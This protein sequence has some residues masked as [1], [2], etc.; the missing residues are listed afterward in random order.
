MKAWM[1]AGLIGAAV[2]VVLS[3]LGLIPF[4]ACITGPLTFLAYIGIGSLAA[5][6]LPARRVAGTAAGQGA[7]AALLAGFIGGIFST[8]IA[9]AQAAMGGTARAFANLPPEMMQQFRDLGM[10]PQMFATSAGAVG[11]AAITGLVCCTA[12]IFIAAALGAIGAAI[13]ASVKPE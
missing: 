2:L 3:L 7:L 1:K 8:I 10:D 4:L 13:Y 11:I 9:V 5:S 12:G 6:Y